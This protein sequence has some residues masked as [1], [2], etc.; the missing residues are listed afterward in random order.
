MQHLEQSGFEIDEG[1][2]V[3][4]KRPPRRSSL[5]T[6]SNASWTGGRRLGWREF[7]KPFPVEWERQRDRLL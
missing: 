3:M 5:P 7:L 1:D 4:R 6:S 2:Q